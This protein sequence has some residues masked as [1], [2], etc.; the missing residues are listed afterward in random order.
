MSDRTHEVL[1]LCIGQA[2]RMR[3][4]GED[5]GIFKKPVT[6]AVALG[7][8]GFAGDVICDLENHGGAMKAVYAMGDGDYAYWQERLGRD[9]AAGTFGENLLLAGMD[10]GRMRCGDRLVFPDAEIVVTQPR[11]P[12]AKLAERM[13][14]KLFAR[15]FMR[16]DHPGFYCRVARPGSIAAGQAARLVAAAAGS[17][18]IARMFAARRKGG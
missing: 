16:S 2:V 18:T 11:I 12:C 8:S 10:S 4:L 17:S 14:D 3:Q 9:L 7:K 5:S 13:N 15:Q 1:A 6:G